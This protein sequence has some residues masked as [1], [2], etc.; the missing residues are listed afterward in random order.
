MGSVSLRT[1]GLDRSLGM[2]MGGRCPLG[3]RSFP[4]RPLSRFRRLLGLGSR[5]V[6]GTALVCSGPGGLVWRSAIWL[7]IWM[8]PAGLW[9]TILSVVWREP[10]LLPERQYQQHAHRQH[11]E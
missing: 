1:L 11:H 3:I 10:G 9:R 5:T 4:L 2:D 8:V 6:L 7:R